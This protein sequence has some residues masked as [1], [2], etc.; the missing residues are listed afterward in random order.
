MKP[1]E[2]PHVTVVVPCYNE[3]N[4][5][6]RIFEL[7]R[8]AQSRNWEWLFVDDGSSD[9]TAQDIRDFAETV[10]GVKLLSL[11]R[12]SG[13]GCAVRHGLAMGIG[14]LVGYVDADL[15]ADPLLFDRYSEDQTLLDGEE[16]LLGIR[17]KTH[18]GNVQRLLY[19]HLMGRAFQTYASLATGLTV[20]DTQCGFKLMSRERAAELASGMTCDGFAFDVEL[21]ML[22]KKAG[23]RLRE[24]MIP[25][26]EQGDS[27]VRFRHIIQ[28]A[29][30]I[31]R[32]RRALGPVRDS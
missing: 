3:A 26:E 14:R 19:R 10:S 24:E 5:L 29:F 27:R 32:I 25:W 9:S 4:R 23:L 22:A 13:K 7:I 12:N 21:L 30:E 6:G 11:E 2:Q 31:L 8:Q 20:Y 17:V 16:I 1:A 15:A 18:D 28:M